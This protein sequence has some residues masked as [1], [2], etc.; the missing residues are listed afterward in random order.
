MSSEER[1]N[2]ESAK[3]FAGLSSLVSDV[4]T[5][6]RA[7]VSPEPVGEAKTSAAPYQQTTPPPSGTFSIGKWV[8]GLGAVIIGLY[9]WSTFGSVNK[10]TT[11]STSYSSPSL[12]VDLTPPIATPDIL[13]EEKSQVGTNATLGTTQLHYCLAEDIRIEAAE[14]VLNNHIESDVDHFNAMVADYNSRCG[15]FRYQRGTLESAKSEV[16][17]YRSVLESEGRGRFA[18]Y[19]AAPAAPSVMPTTVVDFTIKPDS[20]QNTAIADAERVLSLMNKQVGAWTASRYRKAYAAFQAAAEED[21]LRRDFWNTKANYATDLANKL[22]TT[23]VKNAADRS[24]T[25]T[26][27]STIEPDSDQNTAIADAERVLSLMNKQVGAWTASRYR[28]AYAAFQAAAEEDDLRRDFWNTKANY[29]TDLANKLET[30]VVADTV[31]RAATAVAPSLNDRREIPATKNSA[32]PDFSHLSS[33]EKQSIESAC[34]TDKHLNGP[35][36]YNKCLSSQLGELDRQGSRPDL[37]HLTS[38]EQQSIESACSTDKHLNGPAAY[39]KCLSSQLGELDRQGSRP[40]FSH[41]SSAEKQSIESA[42]STDKHLNGPAAYNKCLSS[43]LGELDRQGSRPDL[44]HLTSAEQQSIESACST[45]KHLNG[46]AAYNKCLSSQLGELDR[47]GSRPDLSH[48]TSAEQQSIESA[49]STDK[50]LNGPAAYN[51]CLF[52]QLSL[53]RN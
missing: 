43:Q 30:T 2:D 49:C 14:G 13:L 38:A 5:T 36:A 51:S 7:V 32:R 12:S 4:D 48:L 19:L 23:V 53:L 47:Q 44:S 16:E 9:L 33:A 35:A 52:R 40:D 37:S 28:K 20:D 29:A 41:L 1:K 10:N 17:R 42:C 26:V 6:V 22:E 8:L 11:L 15:Q 27:D 31:D 25:A 34:S 21:D 18:G 45:D 46:P 24:A 3:G 50:H 39:N